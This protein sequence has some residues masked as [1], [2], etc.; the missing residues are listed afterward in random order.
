VTQAAILLE[1]LPEAFSTPGLGALSKYCG[2]ESRQLANQIRRSNSAFDMVQAADVIV[3]PVQPAPFDQGASSRTGII[4][5]TGA[6]QPLPTA[7]TIAG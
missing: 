7:P 2:I 5:T 6:L 3:T 4:F 1:Q